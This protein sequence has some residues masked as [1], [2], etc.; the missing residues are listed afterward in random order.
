MV[1][2]C[3]R[4]TVRVEGSVHPVLDS[5]TN[6]SVHRLIPEGRDQ[7]SQPSPGTSPLLFLNQLLLVTFFFLKISE[8]ELYIFK[9]YTPHRR[10]TVIKLINVSSSILLPLCA[11]DW[12]CLLQDLS[13]T[14]QT[15]CSR[16]LPPDALSQ[17][18]RL[19]APCPLLPGTIRPVPAPSSV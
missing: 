14:L 6:N 16:P 18:P 19:R 3:T 17:R 13:S 2:E 4:G 11:S 8:Q 5:Y 10:I 9:V 12:G 15:W 1:A 7:P